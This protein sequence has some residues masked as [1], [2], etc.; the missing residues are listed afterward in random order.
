VNEAKLKTD[1]NRVKSVIRVMLDANTF[2]IRE[3]NWVIN[4]VRD[5]WKI[6]QKAA[7]AASPSLN[8]LI[9]ATP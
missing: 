4:Y 6:E 7:E 5:K 1:A 3:K 8:L 9:F 2:S